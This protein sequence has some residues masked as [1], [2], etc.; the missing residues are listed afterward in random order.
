M[1]GPLKRLSTYLSHSWSGPN[2]VQKKVL[3][4]EVLKNLL[5]WNEVSF[6]VIVTGPLKRLPMYLSHRGSGP[7]VVRNKVLKNLLKWV[8]FSLLFFFFKFFL[9]KSNLVRM[10]LFEILSFSNEQK[11]ILWTTS[12]TNHNVQFLTQSH[13]LEKIWNH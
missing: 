10:S 2:V 8:S 3:K 1:T 4:N 6:W 9:K 13:W 7:N 5:F 12:L 11:V